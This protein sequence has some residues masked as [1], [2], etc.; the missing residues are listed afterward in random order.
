MRSVVSIFGA[1]AAVCAASLASADPSLVSAEVCNA[2]NVCARVMVDKAVVNLYK[3]TPDGSI[4][5]NNSNIVDNE[6]QAKA[7]LRECNVLKRKY[8][9]TAD[10]NTSYACKVE[11]ADD[12]L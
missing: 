8:E 5:I 9:A 4:V 12:S 1:I 2:N 10:G 11:P 7:A 6:V 3:T